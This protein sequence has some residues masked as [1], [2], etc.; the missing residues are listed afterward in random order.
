[1]LTYFIAPRL[2]RH[3]PTLLISMM[4][5]G[6]S[7]L[8]PT[9]NISQTARLASTRV[10]SPVAEAWSRPIE[11]RSTAWDGVTDLRADAALLVAIQ[12]NPPLRI[13]L[14]KIVERRADYV[15]A[16]L[17]PNPTVGLG[18]GI[19]VD[20]LSGAP[21]MVQGLQAL[22]W[23]WTRPDRIAAAEADL[24]EAIMAAASD[25]ASLAAEIGTAHARVV[26][27][28]HLMEFDVANVGIARSNLNL[29]QDLHGVGEASRLDINRATID[30]QSSRSS[31]VFATRELEQRQLAL[32]EIMGW[33]DHDTLWRAVDQA[34]PAPTGGE[35]SLLGL[36]ATQ[37]LDL[38][39]A[40]QRIR[41]QLAS[42]SLAGTRK[43]PTVEFTLGWQQNFNGRDAVVPGAMISIPILDNGGPAIA[44]AAAQ[45]EQARLAWIDTANLVAYEVRVNTSRWK[46]AA[47]Q[48]RITRE[49]VVPAADA[50]LVQSQAAY[51]GG[52]TT[53]VVLLDAQEALIE[54]E[55][56]LVQQQ[57]LE[58]ESLIELR[59]AVGGTF[60]ILPAEALA[61]E[62]PRE[63]DA[64]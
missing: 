52:V 7:S 28:Q 60:E 37:R 13:S 59:R 61:I 55:R 18:I 58:T 47:Q 4:L 42:L 63:G 53:L 1:M 23:L 51:R 19:A 40:E 21:A 5:A 22:T 32:L 45:L 34:V 12:N 50:A 36:A 64:S 30:M 57:L 10:D 62:H 54:A 20:G 16:G 15:Q 39:V 35:R 38:A 41:H 11:E 43:L 49:G 9:D 48:L 44:K 33:P 46:Q 2:W 25:T 14:S 24:Q 3:T 27:A 6:C 8:D 26:A 29:V 56:S 17:L 31:V